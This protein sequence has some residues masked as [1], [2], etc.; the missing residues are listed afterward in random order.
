MFARPFG[1]EINY[2]SSDRESPE[3]GRKSQILMKGERDLDFKIHLTN[4]WCDFEN[5]YCFN[6]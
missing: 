2:S 1:F 6:E 4:N 5:F 3:R